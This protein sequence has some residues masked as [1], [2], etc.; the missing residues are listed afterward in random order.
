M[1][2]DVKKSKARQRYL[3][4]RKDLPEADYRQR[5]KLLTNQLFDHHNFRLFRTVHCF[6]PSVYQREVDTWLIIHHLW[7][8]PNV[9]VLAP[10]CETGNNLSHHLLNSSTTL[11]NNRWGIPEPSSDSPTYSVE[12]IDIVLI[13]LLAFDLLGHRVG[14][15]KGFYDRFLQNCRADALKVGLSLFFPIDKITDVSEN[16]VL[17]DAVVTPKRVWKWTRE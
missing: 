2:L 14:Y 8:L 16:D 3:T 10:R 15:G 9:Q 1:L 7:Q 4:L 6:I 17:L 5:N 11:V 13:P 12:E